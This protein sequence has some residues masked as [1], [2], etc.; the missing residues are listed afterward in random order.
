MV[1]IIEI[2]KRNDEFNVFAYLPSSGGGSQTFL[3]SFFV[4]LALF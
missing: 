1:C 3:P 4:L 2:V